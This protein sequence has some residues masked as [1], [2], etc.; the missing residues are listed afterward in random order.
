[1]RESLI[2]L[3]SS[4]TIAEFIKEFSRTLK[5]YLRFIELVKSEEKVAVIVFD[6]CCIPPITNLLKM[7]ESL[8]VVAYC[9]SKYPLRLSAMPRFFRV[10]AD[11]R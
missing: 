9:P 3:G 6:D 7:R 4:D 10:V 5:V 1:M 2:Y 8:T 11:S